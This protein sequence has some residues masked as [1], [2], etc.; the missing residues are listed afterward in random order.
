MGERPVRLRGSSSASNCTAG[1]GARNR[2]SPLGDRGVGVAPQSRLTSLRWTA[3]RLSSWRLA[4]CS[5]RSTAETWA[6]TVLT[7]MPSRCGDLLVHVAAGDVPQH[8]SLAR[9]ELVELVGRSAARSLARRRRRARSR[10]A[11]A[12]R[13][14]RRRPRVRSPRRA[15]RRRSSSSRSRARRRGSRRSRPRRRPTPKAPGSARRGC[16]GSADRMISTPPPSGMCTSSSTTS[17]SRCDHVDRLRH[18]P[19]SPTTS[20][21]VAQLGA[22]PGA[23]QVVVVDDH[24]PRGRAHGGA[25]ESV[26]PTRV[27][28][29]RCATRP[30]SPRR[31]RCGST[32][33]RPGAPCGRG[34]TRGCR[35]GRRRSSPGRSR[36]R[37]RARTPPPASGASSA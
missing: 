23:E 1:G 22:H 6:S 24:D 7:E 13:P 30:R 18:G 33:P 25:H 17:G 9:R 2:E 12:R 32:P 29:R 21:R 16:S 15:R 34:S 37:G 14:R 31:A 28:L 10:P 26:D 27:P 8:L 3:Q 20:T 36:G 4:S 11:A 19:A 35:G 5:L